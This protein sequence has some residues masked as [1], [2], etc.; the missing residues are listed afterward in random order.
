MNEQLALHMQRT[1]Q[2]LTDGHIVLGQA[3]YAGEVGRNICHYC[4]TKM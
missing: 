4:T 2:M 3:G 1:G